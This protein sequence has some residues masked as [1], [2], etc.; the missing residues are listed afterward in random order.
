MLSASKID[1][2]MINVETDE[3]ATMPSF[4]RLFVIG[5]I[6]KHCTVSVDQIKQMVTVI[7]DLQQQVAQDILIRLLND[8]IRKYMKKCFNE[9]EQTKLIE[10]I[11]NTIILKQFEKEYQ[12]MVTY[13]YKYKYNS[14]TNDNNINVDSKSQDSQYCQ[15]SVFNTDDLMCLIFQ[16]VRL[17]ET[18]DGDLTACSLVNSHW[19]YQSWNPNSIYYSC[20]STLVKNTVRLFAMAS[21]NRKVYVDKSDYNNNNYKCKNFESDCNHNDNH[22]DDEENTITNRDLD[23][24]LSSKWQRVVKAK[25][26]EIAIRSYTIG[27]ISLKLEYLLERLSKLR[28]IVNINIFIHVFDNYFGLLKPLLYYNKENIEQYSV[29]IRKMSMPRQDNYKLKFEPLELIHVKDILIANVYYYIKWSYKCK[30]LRLSLMYIDDNWIKYIIDNCD[31]SGVETIIIRCLLFNKLLNPKTKST[32][33]LFKKFGEKFENLQNLKIR[34]RNTET[35]PCL[36][37]LLRCLNGIIKKNKTMVALEL[38]SD[39]EDN[40]K[41]MKMIQDTQIKIFIYRLDIWIDDG[42]IPI[43]CL[44]SVILN[45]PNFECLAID[46]WVCFEDFAQK[47]ILGLLLCMEETEENTNSNSNSNAIAN[48]SSLK[49]IDI[50]DGHPSIRTSINTIDYINQILSLQLMRKRKLYAKMSFAI[51]KEYSNV[52]EQAFETMCKTAASLL[53]SHK[54]PIELNIMIRE[55]TTSDFSNIY[56]PIF[57]QYFNQDTKNLKN[58]KP[59]IVNKYCRFLSQPIISFEFG[60]NE[61]G[62]DCVG[63]MSFCV[64]NVTKNSDV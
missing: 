22:D 2:W 35:N 32:Q 20:L 49:M 18:F 9:K 56:D 8:G 57:Q 31:C 36:V 3:K 41:L 16:F 7:P 38:V 62:D 23:R 45:N 54:I 1:D 61:D 26:V 27:K 53:I 43:D 25:S 24:I 4:I 42:P 28:S 50:K 5:R 17:D 55:M 19:L 33:L 44:K 59:P 34:Q 29:R 11:F 12:A 21:K 58:I 30:I 48:L 10:I 15:T 14:K 13:K 47:S 51:N 63:T 52:S 6:L 46:N 40:D 64:S 39:F 60:S 37:L